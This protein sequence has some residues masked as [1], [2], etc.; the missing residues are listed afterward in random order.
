MGNMCCAK[1]SNQTGAFFGRMAFYDGFV[2]FLSYAFR[3]ASSRCIKQI[4]LPRAQRLSKR[5]QCLGA[6]HYD[7]SG[8]LAGHGSKSQQWPCPSRAGLPGHQR[9]GVAKQATGQTFQSDKIPSKHEVICRVEVSLTIL[10]QA[11]CGWAHS[12]VPFDVTLSPAGKKGPVPL[13]SNDPSQ[14]R[15][16]LLHGA[17]VCYCAAALAPRQKE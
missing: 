14:Q 4:G 10:A 16:A 15:L 5:K 12:S 8:S 17:S 9:R 3:I 6:S 2:F 7:G 1:A 13:C 11:A